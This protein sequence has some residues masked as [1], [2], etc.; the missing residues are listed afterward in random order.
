MPDKPDDPNQTPSALTGQ[1]KA[2]ETSA[3]P[4]SPPAAA[5]SSTTLSQEENALLHAALSSEGATRDFL[6]AYGGSALITGPVYNAGKSFIKLAA[7]RSLFTEACQQASVAVK[8]VAHSLPRGPHH[9]SIL[10]RYRQLATITTCV[11]AAPRQVENTTG[12]HTMSANI[13]TSPAAIPAAILPARPQQPLAVVRNN[14]DHSPL[15]ASSAPR[16]TQRTARNT[17]GKDS[18]SLP[19]CRLCHK[20]GHSQTRCWHYHCLYCDAAAPGHYAKFCPENPYQGLDRVEIPAEALAILEDAEHHRSITGYAAEL[21]SLNPVA[22]TSGNTTTPS[23]LP[24]ANTLGATNS[25]SK[26]NTRLQSER[27]QTVLATGP[28]YKPRSPAPRRGGKPFIRAQLG[29]LRQ[30]ANTHDNSSGPSLP[31]SIVPSSSKGTI[32]TNNTSPAVSSPLARTSS[33]PGSS[34]DDF[35]DLDSTCEYEF[36]DDALYNINGEGHI[37]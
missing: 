21:A 35:S 29:R 10:R 25:T 19:T 9:D 15:P 31:P 26:S 30:I 14:G 23:L 4:P 32:S 24:D 33:L 27:P 8:G 36:D 2:S 1:T 37:N 34:D 18:H 12:R 22:N 28:V 5:T 13:I 16:R 20:V 7:A 3:G 17:A 6:S 11:G